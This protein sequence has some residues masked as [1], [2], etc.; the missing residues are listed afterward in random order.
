MGH[1]TDVHTIPSSALP[2]DST[3]SVDARY[4][5]KRTM[6]FD[7]LLILVTHLTGISNAD[8]ELLQFLSKEL[9]QFSKVPTKI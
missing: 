5:L 9:N 2:S 6:K 1:W 8:L 3:Y 7:L 4:H